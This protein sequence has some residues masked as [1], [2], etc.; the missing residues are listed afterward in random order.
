MSLEE[1]CELCREMVVNVKELK[2]VAF[3]AK[4][5]FLHK[6]LDENTLMG[7]ISLKCITP[8]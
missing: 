5:I 6:Q 2:K 8:P 4:I 1:E 3:H 7:I